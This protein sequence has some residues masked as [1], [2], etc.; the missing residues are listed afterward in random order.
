MIIG[1]IFVIVNKNGDRRMSTM[2]T[3]TPDEAVR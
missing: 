2:K 3:V 1:P